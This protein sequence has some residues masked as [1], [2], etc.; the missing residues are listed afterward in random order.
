ML[1]LHC[2]NFQALHVLFWHTA[3]VPASG[4]AGALL[5]WAFRFR[6]NLSARGPAA[7]K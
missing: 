2:D 6:A 3:V 1:E 4:A 5:A 7:Q